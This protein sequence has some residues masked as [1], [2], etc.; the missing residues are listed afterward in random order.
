VTRTTKPISYYV[1]AAMLAMSAVLALWTASVDPER[2]VAWG[3]RLLL[4]AGMT[5]AFWHSRPR[6]GQDEARL[7]AGETIRGAIIFAGFALVATQVT[8]LLAVDG[9]L[10]QRAAMA[11]L[12]G[13]LAYIGNGIPKTLTPLSALR[14][15]AV[16][17]QALQRLSGWTW[18]VTGLGFAIAWLVMPAAVAKPVSLALIGGGMVMVVTQIVRMYLSRPGVL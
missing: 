1:A 5:L 15:D 8:R 2:V 11:L 13:F 12:G 16:R 17:L 4:V 14:C 7:G 18:V 6:P 10:S 9:D 3:S